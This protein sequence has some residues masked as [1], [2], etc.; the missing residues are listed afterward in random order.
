MNAL[1]G[2]VPRRAARTLAAGCDVVL[3][4]N[5]EMA[6]MTSIADAVGT[7]AAPAAARWRAAAA[8]RRT[9]R[10]FDAE[11]AERS[12]LALTRARTEQADGP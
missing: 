5:G 10:D 9:P 1:S 6:E 2:A 7:L 12:L 4:G 11:A 3:H 8:Q